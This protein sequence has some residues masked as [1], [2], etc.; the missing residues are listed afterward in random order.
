MLQRPMGYWRTSKSR[1]AFV[2]SVVF[3]HGVVTQIEGELLSQITPYGEE[4]LAKN[5]RWVRPAVGM[6]PECRPVP[7][8]ADQVECWWDN[9]TADN[10][11]KEHWRGNLV[12]YLGPI[13]KQE[14]FQR[15]E[16]RRC[17]DAERKQNELDHS[18]HGGVVFVV[19]Q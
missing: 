5:L 8:E 1:I 13:L 16:S 14:W 4:C 9:G 19:V 2:H 11:F 18:D 3:D 7:L 6:L 12:E 10:S 17:L 15:I